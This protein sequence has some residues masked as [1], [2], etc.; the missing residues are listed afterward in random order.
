MI[1]LVILAL[2]IPA[3]NILADP[4]FDTIVE[5]NETINN[6]IIVFDGDLEIRSG[7]VVNGDVIV[8]NG[9]AQL[10]GTINGDL[11][12]F[13]GDLDASGEAAIHGDCVLLNGDVDD[14][15]ASGVRCTNIEGAGLSGITKGLPPVPAVPPI[16]AI[17]AV[18]DIPDVPPVPPVPPVNFEGQGGADS[19]FVDFIR[20]IGSSLLLGL[21]AY[22]VTSAFP[23]QMHQVKATIRNKP[24]AS[25]AVGIL[26][27]VAVPSIAVLLAVLSAILIIIC[28]GILGFPLI[29]VLLLG[30]VAAILMGW[31]AVGSWIGGRL[32]RKNKWSPAKAAAVGTVILTFG[33][34]LL[35]IVTGEWLQMILS[36]ILSSI[37]LGAVA[38][39]QFGRK[40]Y[41]RSAENAHVEEDE[42]KIA[43][44]LNTLP[45]EDAGQPFKKA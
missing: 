1:F 39:T 8:F 17:P 38:L 45:D 33:L 24:L 42:D 37:G 9:D 31:I 41:P 4:F 27:A 44:V 15:S 35:G 25:G 7:G 36:T 28:I 2:T 10:S 43:I 26:T 11:V 34:G 5:E 3:G 23:E 13:N 18:P 29:L 19:S 6:D 21:L 16:P 32:F 12:I 40:P 14:E 22:G 20:A 30:F